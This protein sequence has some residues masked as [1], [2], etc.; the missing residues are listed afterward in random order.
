MFLPSLP[1][2]SAAG[3]EFL[4][5]YQRDTPVRWSPDDLAAQRDFVRAQLAGCDWLDWSTPAA[6]LQLAAAAAGQVPA[7]PAQESEAVV[8]AGPIVELLEPLALFSQ[9]RGPLGPGGRLVGIMPCLRDNSPESDLFI[10]HA[11]AELWPYYTAE[12]LLEM[13]RETVWQIQST[14]CGFTPIPRFNLAVLDD[15]LGF[16]GFNR[17]FARLSA[18]GYDPMEVGWGELR[19]VADRG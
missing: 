9:A 10:H 8:L 6:A 18:E 4:E 2:F 17:I 15:Q 7:G 11:K 19:F 16:K 5:N 12:E 1:I 14:V 3:A 13:L